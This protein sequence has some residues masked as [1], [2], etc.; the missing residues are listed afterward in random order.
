MRLST[1]QKL[2]GD[3]P[4]RE[5]MKIPLCPPFSKGEV[6]L[7]GKEGLREIFEIHI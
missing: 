3:F 7:F 6:P 5:G 2:G 1:L 4:D